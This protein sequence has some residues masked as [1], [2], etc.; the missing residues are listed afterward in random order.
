MQEQ[1]RS[2]VTVE[3][4]AS[5]YEIDAGE[6]GGRLRRVISAHG[7]TPNQPGGRKGSDGDWKNFADISPWPPVIGD[8]LTIVWGIETDEGGEGPVVR[9]TVT[10]RVQD[11]DES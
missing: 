1:V 4:E 8:T 11:V 7:P 9:R 3:T 10:S 6:S 5:I 2:V